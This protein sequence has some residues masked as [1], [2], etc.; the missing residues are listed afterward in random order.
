MG[1]GGGPKLLIFVDIDGYPLP[2]CRGVIVFAQ[3]IMQIACMCNIIGL[4]W[5]KAKKIY[6]LERKPD[7]CVFLNS[8]ITDYAAI[9]CRWMPSD[10]GFMGWA[11]MQMFTPD[12]MWRHIAKYWSLNSSTPISLQQVTQ[13]LCLLLLYIWGPEEGAQKKSRKIQLNPTKTIL[14]STWYKWLR[15]NSWRRKN[16][17]I[18][19]F[20]FSGVTAL[21][22]Q[23][24]LV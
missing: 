16:P 10:V 19:K 12:Y 18:A 2:Q 3:Y 11:P 1:L 8:P 22:L 14:R 13:G 15:Q 4:Q 23:K 7:I 9:I 21:G 17:L 24:S 20:N 6:N 5:N